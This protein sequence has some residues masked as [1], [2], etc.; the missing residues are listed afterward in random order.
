MS[1]TVLSLAPLAGIPMEVMAWRCNITCL[2]ALAQ[3]VP[4]T[5]V[6]IC[7]IN[8]GPSQHSELILNAPFSS[9]LTIRSFFSSVFIDLPTRAAPLQCDNVLHIVVIQ[10]TMIQLNKV[11]QVSELVFKL[12]IEV[13]FQISVKE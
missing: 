12:H 2:S 8:L 10:L 1:F 7:S 11:D 5:S 13:C 9:T 6:V 3:V 4:S